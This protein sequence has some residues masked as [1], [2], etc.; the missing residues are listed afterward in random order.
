MI[1]IPLLHSYYMQ[2]WGRMHVLFLK[3]LLI[4]NHLNGLMLNDIYAIPFL[5]HEVQVS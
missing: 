3:I 4:E 2:V 5:L 1:T